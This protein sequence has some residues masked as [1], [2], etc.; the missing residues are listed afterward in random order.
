M[1]SFTDHVEAIEYMGDVEEDAKRAAWQEGADIGEKRVAYVAA[2]KAHTKALESG[3]A[4]AIDS[5][6]A[7]YAKTRDAFMS[8]CYVSSNTF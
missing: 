4:D 8:A 3:D 1:I 5:T 7:E 6:W 2:H